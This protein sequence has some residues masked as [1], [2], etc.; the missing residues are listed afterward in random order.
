MAKVAILRCEDYDSSNVYETVKRA[1]DLIGGINTFIKPG[2]KV[3]LKPNLLSPRPPEDAVTTHPEVVRAVS[4]LVRSAGG[5]VS[6]GDAPGGYGKNIDEILETS[7]IKRMANEEGIEIKK[8]STPKFIDGFPIALDYLESDF[9]ISI[10]KF[11]THM[12]T[13]ITAAVKNMFG[14]V[15]GPHKTECHS[16]APREEDFSKIIAKVYSIS[17]PHLTVLDGIAVMEGDGPSAG[18][19]RK[20]NLIMAGPDAVA[21]DACV[22]KIMGLE[23]LKVLVIKE[24]SVMGLGESD[25]TRIEIVGDSIEDFIAKDFKLPRTT[26]LKFIP[27]GVINMIAALIKFKPYIDIGLCKRCNLCKVSCPVDCITIAK[28][29]CEIDYK[30]CVK[31]LCCHEVCPYKAIC[32]KRN[33]LTKMIW[34]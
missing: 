24:V 2:M 4:R 29:Y 33:F 5:I 22:A 16:R 9:V 20:M 12:I 32:I 10:P 7:G 31:C 23:P 34:G 13:V 8:F 1:I 18:I 6:L 14:T 3:L 30:K 28:D 19:T 11:K 21:I 26:P 15:V 27:K 25:L 17:K